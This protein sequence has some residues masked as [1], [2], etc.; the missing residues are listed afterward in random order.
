VN[1]YYPNA[2]TPTFIKE[3]FIKLKTHIELHI[4]IVGDF[5]ISL[6]PM[7]RSLK[8]KISRDTVKLIEVMNQMKLTDIYK[9]FHPK[10][11]EYTF[12]GPHGTFFKTDHIVAHKT[13]LNRYKKTKIIPCILSDHHGLKAG[14]Q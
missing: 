1:I 5:N 12:S 10:T 11:K 4:I 7:D 3:T 13:S 8:Q 9:T 6:S 14:L 2:R